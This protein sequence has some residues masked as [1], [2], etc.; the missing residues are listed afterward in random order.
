M[1]IFPAF[2]KTL[3]YNSVTSTILFFETILSRS[4]DLSV[5]VSIVLDSGEH[6]TGQQCRLV[7]LP[8]LNV[9]FNLLGHIRMVTAHNYLPGGL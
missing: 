6:L 7:P 1:I 9:V 8:R 2:S 5:N 3:K 4:F